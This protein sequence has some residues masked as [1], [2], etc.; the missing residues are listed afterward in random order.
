MPHLFYSIF[1]QCNSEMP[2]L[3]VCSSRIPWPINRPLHRARYPALRS[4]ELRADCA[5]FAERSA[6]LLANLTDGSG[7]VELLSYCAL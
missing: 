6:Y 4:I 5:F 2:L 3:L 7:G 1:V